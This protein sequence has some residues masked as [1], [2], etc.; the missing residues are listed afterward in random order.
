[1]WQFPTSPHSLV[2]KPSLSHQYPARRCLFPG[3][4]KLPEGLQN[5]VFG[6]RFKQSL[7]GVTLPRSIK[8]LTLPDS[9]NQRLQNVVL[10]ECLETRSSYY[11]KDVFLVACLFHLVTPNIPE[12]IWKHGYKQV[13]WF[14]LRRDCNVTRKAWRLGM[15]STRACRR[16]SFRRAFAAWPLAF[17]TIKAWKACCFQ[18]SS[19]C[20]ALG[21]DSTTVWKES[22][23]RALY[24]VSGFLQ[25]HSPCCFSQIQADVWQLH[26]QLKSFFPSKEAWI[27]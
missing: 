8:N 13:R 27:R 20:W 23:C 7:E 18:V 2:A 1:M 4:V 26:L 21:I 10:P 17:G 25:L 12:I 5:L 9:W 22:A 24:K 16:W 11:V 14:F 3:E 15:S 19:R 6:M